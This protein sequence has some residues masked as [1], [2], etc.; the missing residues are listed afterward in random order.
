MG[1]G[2]AGISRRLDC[3]NS[4]NCSAGVCTCIY[5]HAYAC[6][7]QDITPVSFLAAPSSLLSNGDGMSSFIPF[8]AMQLPPSAPREGC[9]SVLKCY[10]AAYCNFYAK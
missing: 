10:D 7:A 3:C 2:D 1:S 4:R 8:I 6:A 5:L 9:V